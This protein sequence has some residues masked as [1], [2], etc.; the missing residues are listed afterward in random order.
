VTVLDERGGSSKGWLWTYLDP[1]TRQ[2]FFDATRT[3]ERDGPAAFLA[4]F[5]GML[6]ADASTGYDGLFQDGRILEIGC[7]AHPRGGLSRPS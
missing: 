5:R 2:V 3:H 4:D 6:Q 1:L 7:W